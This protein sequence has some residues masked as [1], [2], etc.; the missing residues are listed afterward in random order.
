MVKFGDKN[1]PEDAPSST[2]IGRIAKKY[3]LHKLSQGIS[4]NYVLR[5]QDNKPR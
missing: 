3:R 2:H 5:H 1:H 4:H